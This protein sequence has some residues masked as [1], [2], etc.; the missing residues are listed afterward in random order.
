MGLI[1]AKN[2]Q[3]MSFENISFWMKRMNENSKK[4]LMEKLFY[5]IYTSKN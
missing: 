5:L 2:Q 1:T 4:K 3:Q